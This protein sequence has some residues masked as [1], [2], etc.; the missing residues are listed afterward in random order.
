MLRGRNPAA[1]AFIELPDVDKHC[2]AIDQF[3]RLGGGDMGK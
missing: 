3:F 1:C 2:A